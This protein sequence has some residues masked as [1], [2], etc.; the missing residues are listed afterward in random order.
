LK[1]KRATRGRKEKLQEKQS[2]ETK[3]TD[4]KWFGLLVDLEM[5]LKMSAGHKRKSTLKVRAHKG[6]LTTVGH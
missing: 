1:K 5:T 3:K 6:P 4:L 2:L